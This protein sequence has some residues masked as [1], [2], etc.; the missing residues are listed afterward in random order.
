MAY[1]P[2]SKYVSPDGRVTF[3]DA[4]QRLDA[5]GHGTG[6]YVNTDDLIPMS[7]LQ[8][9]EEQQPQGAKQQAFQRAPGVGTRMTQQPVQQYQPPATAVQAPAQTQAPQQG[10]SAWGGFGEFRAQPVQQG[11]RVQSQYQAPPAGNLAQP[12]VTQPQAPATQ[13]R[14]SAWGAW[15]PPQQAPA[16]PAAAPSYQ[17]PATTWNP[18]SGYRSYV[19]PTPPPTLP[20]QNFAP[21]DYQIQFQQMQPGD[22]YPFWL[23]NQIQRAQR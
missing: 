1:A 7:W 20:D 10:T 2:G 4:G 8:P 16:G 19:P 12:Q 11:P 6:T 14:Q 9:Q 17:P 23:Q 21:Y 18:P 15:M 13:R 5:L 3:D 22:A